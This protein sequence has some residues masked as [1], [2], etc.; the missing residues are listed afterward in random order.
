MPRGAGASLGLAALVIGTPV[1]I[2][3]QDL[4]SLIARQPS[5]SE[6]WQKHLLSS[7]FGT[8]HAATFSFPRPLGMAIPDPLVYRL[9]KFSSGE[10]DVTGSISGEAAY[11]EGSL[12]FPSIDRSHKGDRADR[13]LKG[14]RLAVTPPVGATYELASA[15]STEPVSSPAPLSEPPASAAVR[16]GGEAPETPTQLAALAPGDAAMQQVKLSAEALEEEADGA[17]FDRIAPAFVE[18]PSAAIRTT[19]LYFGGTPLGPGAGSIE[20]WG[21]GEEP[22]LV[23]PADP[24]LKTS[25]LTPGLSGQHGESIASKGE[26]TGEGRRPK[27][28]AE[29]LGLTGKARAKAEKCLTDAVYFEARGEPVRGQMAVAQV[30]MNRVFSGYYPQDV[31]GVVYQNANRHLACQFTFACDGIPE[32]VTEPDAWARAKEIAR[33]TLDGKIWVPAVGKATHYHAYWVHPSWVH[34]MKKMLKL[35][36]HTFYRP[37]NWGDGSDAPVWGDAAETAE[38]IKK[39]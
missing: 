28:P 6:H 14:D 20:P 39:L 35:G 1:G 13:K 34:E 2:G 24:D 22:V 12:T 38:V 31:C 15:S 17:Q 19:R 18:E 21:P 33:D 36:V 27:S 11:G 32:R 9:A 37:R 8:L 30:V 23:N 5:V 29:R 4:A 16:Q 10:G 26:V 3:Y 7:P 25:S